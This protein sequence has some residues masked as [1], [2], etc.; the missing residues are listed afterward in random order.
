[1]EPIYPFPKKTFRQEGPFQFIKPEDFSMFGIDPLHVPLGTFVSLKHPSQLRSK[2]GGNAYG[3]GLFEDFDRLRPKEIRHLQSISL[4]KPEEIKAHYREINEIYRKMGLLI[5]F[6][7]FGKPYYLIPVHLISNTL[8]HIR[9][10]VDEISKVI[11]FHR[12]K[13]LKEYHT[14]GV[15]SRQDEL[16]L[17]EL[18]LRFKEHHFVILD[19]LEK[20]KNLRQKLD[21]VIILSDLS[22]ISLME[23]FSYLTKEIFS[24]KRFYQY[25]MYVLWK[26]FNLLDQNGEL[27]VIADYFVEKTT[28]TTKVTFKNDQEEKSFSLFCHLFKTRKRYEIVDHAVHINLYD[29]QKYLGAPYVE[30][31]V[32][33]RLLKGK[34]VEMLSLDEISALP[35][36]D[37]PFADHSVLENQKKAW[38]K[39]FSVFF[40][41]IFLRSVVPEIVSEDWES[42]FSCEGYTPNF[43]MTY[44]GQKKSLNPAIANAQ[45]DV[46]SSTLTGCSAGLVADYKDSFE[47]VIRTLRILAGIKSG[48]YPS[49]PKILLDRL[50]QPFENKRRRHSALGYVLKLMGKTTLLERIRNFLNPEGIE[51]PRTAVMEHI[52]ILD[53]FG[54]GP[55]EV[56]EILLIVLGHTPYGR[57]ISGKA[58]EKALKPVSEMAVKYDQEQ[59][60]NLFR[61]C[62]LMTM[63]ETEA[64]RGKVLSKEEVMQLFSLYESTV[65]VIINE[66]LDWDQLIEEKISSMGGMYNK[67]IQKALM[68]M[69]Y[70]EFIPGWPELIQKG[71][72]QKE[73]LADYNEQKLARIQNVIRLQQTVKHF[74]RMYL[75]SDPLQHPVFYRR[76]LEMEF[77]GTG[78]LF[79]K[80]DSRNVFVLLWLSVHLAHGDIINV[81]PVLADVQKDSVEERIHKIGKEASFINIRHLGLAMLQHFKDQLRRYHFSFVAGTGFQFKIDENTNALEL[82]FQDI[83]EN[84]A[85]AENL[86]AEVRGLAAADIPLEKFRRLEKFFA[87]LEAFYQSHQ[88]LLRERESARNLPVR[89]NKWI[90]KIE[91]LRKTLKDNLLLVLFQPPRLFSDLDLLFHNAPTVLDFLLPEFMALKDSDLAGHTSLS[92]SVT[93]YIMA[94]AKKFQALI[95]HEKQKFQDEKFLHSLAQ[96]EFGPMATGIVG[97]SKTQ[98]E[99]LENIVNRLKEFPHLFDALTKSFLFQDIGRLRILRERYRN[100]INPADS[101]DAGAIFLERENIAARYDF[102]KEANAFLIFLVKHHSLLYRNLRGEISLSALQNVLAPKDKNLFD[103]FFVLSVIMLSAIREDLILEDFA[104]QLFQIRSMCHKIIDGKITLENQFDEVF[105][106]KGVL[107]YA[108]ENYKKEGLPEALTPTEFLESACWNKMDRSQL[109]HAGKMISAMERI[110]KLRGIRYIE[111]QDLV[112][113]ELKLPLEFIHKKRKLH[114]VGYATFE[115]EVYEAFRIYKTLHKLKEDIRHFI[116]EKLE[117]DQVRIS[118]YEKTSGYLRYENQVK[119]LLLG[120][121]G[122][123]SV[124]TRQEDPVS[125]NFLPIREKIENRYEAVN[126]FLTDLPLEKL[127]KGTDLLESLFKAETGILLKKESYSNLLSVDFRDKNDITPKIVYMSSIKDLEQLKN[128]FQNT[129]GML[130]K[131]PYYTEDYALQLKEAFNRRIKE[132]TKLALDRVAKQMD[133]VKDFE[134]LHTLVKD[135]L[136]RGWEQVFSR[137]QKHLLEY[138][139]EMRK[140]KLK[141]EKLQEIET[142]L[143]SIHDRQELMDYWDGMKWYLQRNRRFFGKEFE[144]LIALKFDQADAELRHSKAK[145]NSA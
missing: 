14:I 61:Y 37:T 68:M 141:A 41:E 135:L 29:L 38:P 144:N 45:N 88:R 6:S 9:A 122:T 20:I 130:T 33:D 127:W 5:R 17:H 134:D 15:L 84:I 111:F 145:G 32:I 73:A 142:T 112:H 143:A 67:I 79:Q 31:D 136:E 25:G 47:Y 90:E 87:G 43:L 16:V 28:K 82:H 65:R 58:S 77:H 24:K 59:V 62:R 10:R 52:P 128:Y 21:L 1:M 78:H 27:F 119:L 39:I 23:E 64:A 60:L 104:D 132:I 11:A 102:S 105:E 118:G 71:R 8:T 138:L 51:G 120:L 40:D 55:S 139:Y 96:K 12:K 108:L 129:L 26:V 66:E 126:E 121:M 131:Q 4:E 133:L 123:A 57:I 75:V 30:Q 137:E 140:D 54:F 22:E 48:D 70:A 99:H 44:L 124:K 107:F 80:M 114:S 81:N 115:K 110:F 63:A 97:I 46:V 125:L 92:S 83:E 7:A 100:V 95:T 117:G 85:H 53:I 72:M 93:A 18:S 106:Q 116:L 56:K 91:Q 86:L 19:S 42:R 50:K 89:Q 34:S 98:L 69:N 13:Y 103:A 94:A 35:F 36:L 109:L 74:E 2:F 113:L 3:C 49:L 76:F 101:A